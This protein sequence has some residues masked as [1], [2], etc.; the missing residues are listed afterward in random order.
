MQELYI[1]FRLL[2]ELFIFFFRDSYR[3]SCHS[4]PKGGVL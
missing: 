4:N 2:L 3:F 1:Y